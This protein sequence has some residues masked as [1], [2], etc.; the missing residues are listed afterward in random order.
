MKKFQ[1]LTIIFLFFIFYFLFSDSVSAA[2]LYLVPQSQTIYRD[3]SFLVEVRLDTED[4]AI[5]V[6]EAGLTFPANLLK[7]VDFNKGNSILTLWLE[8][9]KIQE[10]GITFL[11][12]IPNGFK[13]DGLLG[14]IIFW[15]ME[16]GKAKISF[17]EDSKVLL[18]NGKGTAAELNFL[19]SNYEIIEK[20]EG[21]P[22]VS[23]ESHPDQNKW[24]K[25][26]TLALYW[27]PIE[28]AE[29]SYQLSFD[30]ISEPDETPDK[31]EPKEGVASWI[32]AM[33][34][35]LKGEEDGIYYFS[36]RQKLPTED[37]SRAVRFRAMI[38]ATPSE[39]FTPEIGQDSTVFEGKYFLSFFTTDKMSGVEHYEILETRN[40][41]IENRMW[42]V[43]ESPYLLE[44]Q[45]LRSKI[46]V[47]VVDRAGNERIAEIPPS[48]KPFPYWIII[49]I[50]TGIG[51]IWWLIH[52][53]MQKRTQKNTK[54]V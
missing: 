34:Y 33:D 27:E 24:Y 47:K 1:K 21:L 13:G 20:P 39:E 35:D 45:S 41:K 48:K 2:S 51:V 16:T 31:P 43:G 14:K 26:K 28:G 44:D 38:D 42:K 22:Q 7:A 32:G 46:L 23:S 6:V 11:G 19:E 3:E 9:T 4:E 36:L 29:Y 54:F 25:S 50:L 8:E 52:R 40:Q 15:G 37:W 12:G 49:L 53:F 17:K 10:G 30:P 18:N 5:N